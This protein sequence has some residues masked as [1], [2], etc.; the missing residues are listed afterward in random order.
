MLVT[1]KSEKNFQRIS[2]IHSYHRIIK[3]KRLKD[4]KTGFCE[5]FLDCL[6][7]V[8]ENKLTSINKKT[9]NKVS[10][11]KRPKVFCIN[12]GR[13]ICEWYQADS[14]STIL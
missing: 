4:K 11:L 2:S 14:S 13:M 5:E 9:W 7:R 3:I 8:V 10:Y 12:D 1:E 6:V